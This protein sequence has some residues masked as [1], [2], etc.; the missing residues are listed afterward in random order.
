MTYI[1]ALNSSH[2]VLVSTVTQSYENFAAC[3][4]AYLDIPLAEI[5]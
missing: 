3:L 4:E 5:S 1:T 2:T